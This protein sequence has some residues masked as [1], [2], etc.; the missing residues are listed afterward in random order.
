MKP[1]PHVASDDSQDD[2]VHAVR[3][4][5]VI[6]VGMFA[7]ILVGQGVFSFAI[8]PEPYPSVRMPNFGTAASSDGTFD[9]P[10]ARAEVVNVDGSIDAIS[11]TALMAEFRF[12]TARPSFDYLFQRSEPSKITP[13][14]RHWLRE[15]IA[16]IAADTQ[17]AELRM[18]WQKS[19][20]SLSDASVVRSE[21]CL[22]KVVTL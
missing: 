1:R 14:V 5:R 9:V 3:P 22:W 4:W 6:A 12:S 11:P 17:P 20:V 7:I 10:L 19:S 21:P 18:C 13:K 2:G 8:K 15:R 16:E